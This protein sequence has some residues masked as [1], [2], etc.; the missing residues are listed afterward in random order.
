VGGKTALVLR[1]QI[2][3][4]DLPRQA[5]DKHKGKNEKS[6]R[7]KCRMSHL[8]TSGLPCGLFLSMYPTVF[9][10]KGIETPRALLWSPFVC[11]SRACLVNSKAFSI[12]K[13]HRKNGVRF[14][15][16]RI[17]EP[18][19]LRC[20]QPRSVLFLLCLSDAA[21]VGETLRKTAF[22]FKRVFSWSVSSL[23]W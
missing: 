3:I 1:F 13:S 9:L 6:E 22:S 15:F 5:R 18:K 23:S 4:D 10:R 11:L 21:V 14:I 7:R 8:A 19:R 16:A 17:D 12:R 20:L 2:Q